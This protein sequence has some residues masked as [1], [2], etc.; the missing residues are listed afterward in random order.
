MRIVK[1]FTVT[2]ATLISSTVSENDF[3]V[4]NSSTSYAFGQQVIDTT[5]HKV[6]QSIRGGSSVVTI[7]VANPAVINWNAHGLSNGTAVTFTTTGSLPTGLTV[8]TTYYVVNATTNYFNVAATLGGTAIATSGTPSGVH[9]CY[10]TPNL[11][12]TP[13]TSPSWWLDMG[14]TNKW[15]AFDKS[16]QSQTTATTSLSFTVNVTQGLDTI[17]LLNVT[18]TSARVTVTH[19]TDGTVYDYTAKVFTDETPIIDM[20]SYF[21]TDFR[22]KSDLIFDYLPVYSNANV[23]VTMSGATGSTVGVGAAIYGKAKDIS[24][25][26]LGVEQGAKVGITDYSV[27]T[28]DAFGNYTITPRAFAKRANWDVYVNTS[29]IDFI[30]NYLAGIRATPILF[31]GGK[32]YRAT[33]I[34]GYYKSW[35]LNIA[36]PTYSICTMEIDGLT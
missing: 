36:Y 17:A 3:P 2:D 30:Q 20:W 1:P 14:S 16:V 12:N 10:D 8:G 23:T 34:Y 4:Y 27:K 26:K 5:L 21:F 19:P 31:L 7:T 33:A 25:D 24:C 11:N 32:Q 28:V 22:A 35:E 9:T 18:G 29:D 13:S 6:Y 15:R